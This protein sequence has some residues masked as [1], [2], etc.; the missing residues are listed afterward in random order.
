MVVGRERALAHNAGDSVVTF[1][2]WSNAEP[3]T[4]L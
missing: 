3:I 4:L 2:F 1:R